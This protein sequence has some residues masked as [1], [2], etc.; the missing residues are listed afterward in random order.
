MNINRDTARWKTAWRPSLIAAILDLPH[1]QSGCY[2][3]K[4][5]FGHLVW[6]PEVGTSNQ[7]MQGFLKYGIVPDVLS[8]L[9]V[10]GKKR[11]KIGHQVKNPCQAWIV[12]L[13]PLDRVWVF[14]CV[15]KRHVM[16]IRTHRNAAV[17]FKCHE[18]VLSFENN[19]WKFSI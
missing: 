11:L 13:F 16:Q 2:G 4:R 17:F 6:P 14:W 18:Y 3:P 19:F 15:I 5:L 8:R 9:I 1:F 12:F 7:K 10:I